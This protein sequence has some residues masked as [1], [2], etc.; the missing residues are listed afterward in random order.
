MSDHDRTVPSAQMCLT[1]DCKMSQG[2]D[3]ASGIDWDC[4]EIAGECKRPPDCDARNRVR[5]FW[6]FADD[7]HGLDPLM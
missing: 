6:V 1:S 7:W 3:S 5:A 4:G 2:L